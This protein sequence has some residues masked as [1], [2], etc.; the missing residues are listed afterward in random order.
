MFN[1]TYREGQRTPVHQVWSWRLSAV[2]ETPPALQAQTHQL[3]TETWERRGQTPEEP[4]PDPVLPVD[5]SLGLE[6][7]SDSEARPQDPAALLPSSCQEQT[8]LPRCCCLGKGG[9]CRCRRSAQAGE[10]GCQKSCPLQQKEMQSPAPGE[11]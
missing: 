7:R 1:W 9:M 11:E 8:L 5:I 10:M 3:G 6:G 4:T 2:S